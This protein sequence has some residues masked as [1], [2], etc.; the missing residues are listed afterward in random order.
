ML[1]P[2]LPL[3]SLPLPSLSLAR[4]STLFIIA[5]YT[6]PF[7]RGTTFFRSLFRLGRDWA[8]HISS[9]SH[10][11]SPSH[12]AFKISTQ[13]PPPHHISSHYDGLICESRLHIHS[14]YFSTQRTLVTPHAFVSVF[15]VSPYPFRSPSSPP[16]RVEIGEISPLSDSH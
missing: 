11:S 3:P 16:P 10:L 15:H 12:Y 7:T 2:P 1:L 8:L 14:V 4:A 6:Q 5:P 9:S 13:P